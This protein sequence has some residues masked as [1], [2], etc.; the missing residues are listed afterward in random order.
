MPFRDGTQVDVEEIG[1]TDWRVLREMFYQGTHQSFIVPAGATTDFAS[2][3]RVLVWFLPR[4]GRYTRA[5]ILH[6][7]LW[8]KLV[9]A[10]VL[11]LPEADGI[12]R[13]AMRELG[14][15]FLRRWIMWGAVRLGALKKPG[16][17]TRWIRDSWPVLPLALLTLPIV[18]PPAIVVLISL[19]LFT[20]V[21]FI[22]YLPLR[23]AKAVRSARG[24]PVKAVNVP[25]L[26]WKT[27]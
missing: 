24:E 27:S 4:Y 7:H 10:G 23:L 25:T 3:P 9:P 12:F 1:D 2:V 17:R 16:G 13:R 15:P 20:V 14:V 6:D 19:A 21:E 26:E 8:R 22:A 5:A 18:G 11:S